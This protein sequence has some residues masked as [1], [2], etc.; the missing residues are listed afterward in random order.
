MLG[1]LHML[2]NADDTVIFSTSSK[3][4]IKKCNVL[5]SAFHENRLELNLSESSFMIINPNDHDL[6][7]LRTNL[8]LESGW[9]LYKKSVVYFGVIVSDIGIISDHLDAL[10]VGKNKSVF[11]KL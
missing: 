4:F 11:V 3:N 5:L 1:E 10:I 7:D 6:H 8:K 2:L 9:L